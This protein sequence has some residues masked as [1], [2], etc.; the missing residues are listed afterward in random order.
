M[1]DTMSPQDSNLGLGGAVRQTPF[2]LAFMQHFNRSYT[3]GK[4][5][6][7]TAVVSFIADSFHGETMRIITPPQTTP[8]ET[9]TA[10]ASTTVTYSEMARA[11]PPIQGRFLS[12]NMWNPLSHGDTRPTYTFLSAAP[13]CRN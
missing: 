13:K 8:S 5:D 1:Y 4:P 9:T 12:G 11:S 2:A 6:D 3:G 7:T 10:G